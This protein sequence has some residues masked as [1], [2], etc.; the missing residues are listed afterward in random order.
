MKILLPIFMLM[1]SACSSVPVAIK[2]APDPDPQLAKVASNVMTYQG[3]QVRWGGQIIKVENSD[4]GAT[5][6][7]AQFPLNSYGKP[8]S[9]KDSQVA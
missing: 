8:L 4:Q 3:Q 5:L 2:N 7:I 1:L 9:D 6:Q